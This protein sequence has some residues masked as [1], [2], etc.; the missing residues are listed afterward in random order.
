MAGG[1]GRAALPNAAEPVAKDDRWK[2]V[3]AKV[4]QLKDAVRAARVPFLLALTWSFLWASALYT[5]DYGYTT[6]LL[7]RTE[8]AILD[9][10]CPCGNQQS[11]AHPIRRYHATLAT[12]D[13]KHHQANDGPAID[14]THK[15]CASVLDAMHKEILTQQVAEWQFKIPVVGASTTTFDLGIIGNAGLFL[16]ALWFYYASRR[17]NSAIRSFVNN[18][19]DPVSTWPPM[20]E[21]FRLFRMDSAL[22]VEHYAY[23]YQAVAQRFV[24][25]TSRRSITLLG[26]TAFLVA[27]PW[28]VATWNEFTDV[29]DVTIHHLRDVDGGRLAVG[30]VCWIGLTIVSFG[31]LRLLFESSTLLNAWYLASRDLWELGEPVDDPIWVTPNGHASENPPHPPTRRARP[32]AGDPETSRQSEKGQTNNGAS[33]P[34]GPNTPGSPPPAAGAP[35]PPPGPPQPPPPPGGNGAGGEAKG[36]GAAKPAGT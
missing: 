5:H 19:A 10:A 11:T 9:V 22:G 16:I 2:L 23:A 8:S 13:Q 33:G 17:E 4:E 29:R 21:P 20:R 32:P 35:Q 28:L 25:L 3:D 36:E 31:N 26:G 14:R 18:N 1:N 30:L 7:A 27:V 34:A 24:F 12:A 6:V 15:L